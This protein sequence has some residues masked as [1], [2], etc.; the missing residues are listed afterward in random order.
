ML[1]QGKSEESEHE[2]LA[3]L[4]SK[5]K[6]EKIILMGPRVLKH[7]LPKITNHK[8]VVGFENPDEVLKYL[9]ENIKGG[10]TILFKGARYLEGVIENLLADK[11]DASKLARR[12]KNLAGEK[13]KF[14][15]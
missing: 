3:D 11:N 1:E 5:I 6:I 13:E 4:I 15:L 8:K 14:G 12:E 2:K 10:E 9:K 7:T